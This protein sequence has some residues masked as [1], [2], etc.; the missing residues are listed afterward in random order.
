MTS[1]APYSDSARSAPALEL[2][3]PEEGVGHRQRFA[4][5]DGIRAFAVMA[6]LLYHSGI[7]WVGGGLLGVDV[8]FVLSGFLI[9]SLLCAELTRR[10]TVRLGRFW[11]QRA[12]RS[13][14]PPSSCSSSEWPPTPTSSRLDRCRSGPRATPSPRWLYVA[15]WHYIFSDQGYFAQAAA[16]SPLLHT[17]SLG[18]RGAVLPDLAPDRPV[19]PAPVR[20]GR[21]GR[22]RRRGR[23][24][25]GGR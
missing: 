25:L 4:A 2:T 5:L 11:A 21:A 16:P 8:F 15:N 17:W 24:P 12:R 19:R 18:R 22:G 6:V 20:G 10:D 13:A 9:T 23:L 14:R 7:S 1:V 3:S